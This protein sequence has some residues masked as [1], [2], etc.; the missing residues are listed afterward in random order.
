MSAMHLHSRSLLHFDVIR[1]CGS[2]REAARQLHLSSSALNRQLLELEGELG[3]PLFE[4]LPA[5]LK[6]T[7]VGEVLSRHV[8]TV[9][10]DAQRM[11]TELDALKGIRRGTI[12]V[13]TVEALTP[14]FMPA[15]IE[16]MSLRYPGVRMNVRIGGSREAAEGVM[17]AQADVAI[18]FMRQRTENLRQVA[19]GKFHLGAIMPVDHVL[20]RQ[21][22]VSFAD[23]AKYPLI[24]PTPE[25]AIHEE[26]KPLLL[27]CK[28]PHN[29]VLET[30]SFELMK[31]MAMKG[32]GIAFVNR[33]GIERELDEMTLRHVPLKD[34]VLF[35]LGIY[36]RAERV[37]TPAIDAFI[38][39]A[40]EEIQ[41]RAAQEA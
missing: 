9:L 32:L 38:R 8:I 25:I 21:G 36:V 19:V 17:E 35:Y 5:G 1:R 18:C 12:D 23:C 16:T 34:P 31:R 33:F 26:I 37:L 7:P 24:L 6:L 13:L 28:E 4:R 3:T 39:I 30:G 2:I 11:G 14:S 20:A 27:A 29:V 22:Q 10:Q 15:V 40:S 41:Q